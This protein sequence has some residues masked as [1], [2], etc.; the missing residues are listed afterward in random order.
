MQNYIVQFRRV[1]TASLAR[2]MNCY[3]KSKAHA[4]IQGA[5]VFIASGEDVCEI[6]AT[7]SDDT[8][9]PASSSVG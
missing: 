5:R 6:V 4:I 8:Q 2:L 7:E 1:P 9:S 3:A